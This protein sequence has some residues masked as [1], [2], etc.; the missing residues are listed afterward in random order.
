MSIS[1]LSQLSDNHHCIHGL[2]ILGLLT[3]EHDFLP[4]KLSKLPCLHLSAANDPLDHSDL[5]P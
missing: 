2:G 5:P 3:I 1:Y 4:V